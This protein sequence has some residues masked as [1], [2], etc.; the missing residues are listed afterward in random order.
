ME[1]TAKTDLSPLQKTINRS[2][3][4]GV[5]SQRELV[6]QAG[7]FYTKSLM[8]ALPQSRKLRRKL[9]FPDPSPGRDRTVHMVHARDRAVIYGHKASTVRKWR[10]IKYRG[11]ARMTAAE[12]ARQAGLPV[13]YS[14]SPGERAPS[15]ARGLASGHFVRNEMNPHLLFTYYARDI[16]NYPGGQARYKAMGKSARAMSGWAR[17]V[18]KEQA[19]EFNR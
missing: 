19:R 10:T 12:A 7:M 15:K 2:L 16:V 4:R 11:L 14:G 17:R 1:I 13:K 9:T 5:A 18:L 8:R 3:E 6:E